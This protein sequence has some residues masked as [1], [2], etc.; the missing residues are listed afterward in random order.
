MD[1]FYRKYKKSIKIESWVE[2]ISKRT[3]TGS[4]KRV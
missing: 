1:D 4:K 3:G 2:F